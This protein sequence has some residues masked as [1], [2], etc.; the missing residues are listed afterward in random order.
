MFQFHL[1]E[2]FDLTRDQMRGENL[3]TWIF[4]GGGGGG[5][6]V[7]Y[8][9]KI[10]YLLINELKKIRVVYSQST[11]SIFGG[12]GVCELVLEVSFFLFIDLF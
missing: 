12:E 7:V 6:L 3:V 2:H 11:W 5:V 8:T 10:I 9:P 1:Y 4:L